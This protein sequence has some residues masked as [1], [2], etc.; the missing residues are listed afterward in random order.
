MIRNLFMLVAIAAIFISCGGG[1]G[2]NE[3]AQNDTISM[4]ATQTEIPVIAL[5]EFEKIAGNY[6]DQEIMVEGIVDHVCKHGGKRLLL[7]A[8]SGDVHVDSDSRFEESL[9]GSKV[10]LKGKVKEFRVDEAYCLKME[11]DNIKSHSEGQTDDEM[12]EHKMAEI[13]T[14]RDSMS[15]A[16]VDHLS[17]Y[18]IDYITLEVKEEAKD[19]E[20]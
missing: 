17:F 16:G 2:T 9:T 7:V 6:V 18:S 10:M 15:T 8:D 19:E 1:A 20:I 12:Y 13:K 11:E 3:S 5:G 4:E 14:Y